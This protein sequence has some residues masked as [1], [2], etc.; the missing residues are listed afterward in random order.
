MTKRW[1][2]KKTKVLHGGQ[3]GEVEGKTFQTFQKINDLT[4]RQLQTKELSRDDLI[5]LIGS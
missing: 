3:N 2:L 1:R 5:E 4:R